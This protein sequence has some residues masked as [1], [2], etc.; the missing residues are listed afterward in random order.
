MKDEP[1]LNEL[2]VESYPYADGGLEI[3]RKVVQNTKGFLDFFGNSKPNQQEMED[4]VWE[5][6]QRRRKPRFQVEVY[7]D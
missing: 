5:L 7:D 6:K 3:A 1:T 2:V 4:K